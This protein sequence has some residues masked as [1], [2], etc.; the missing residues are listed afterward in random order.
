VNT[1][2]YPRMSGARLVAAYAGDIRF[3]L[4]KM[5]RTPAFAVPTL[6]FPA[7]FYLLFGVLLSRNNAAASLET[8]ARMGVFGTMG[9]GLFGFAVSLAFEREHGLMKFKQALPMPPGA[10]L[11]ARMVM[12]MLF[13]AIIAL[14]LIVLAVTV[15]GTT[16]DAGQA[17]KVFVIEV[18]GVL[19]FCALGLCIGAF[20]SGQASPAIANLIYL[21]MAFLSG[22]WIPLQFLPKAIQVLAPAWPS[23][24]LN[25]LALGALDLPS[26]GRIGAHVAALAGITIVFFVIAMRRLG[27]RGITL[28]NPAKASGRFRLAGAM[29]RAFV[30]LGLGLAAAGAMNGKA[31]DPKPA[32][33]ATAAGGAGAKA[34]PPAGVA[35]PASPLIAAFDTGSAKAAYGTGW[36][37]TS[38]KF[39]GGASTASV[40]VVDGGAAG[41]AGA[42]EIAG[43][44][45]P[46]FQWPFAGAVFFPNGPP[47]EGMMDYSSRKTLVFQARGDGGQFAV[48]FFSTADR[49]SIPSSF[50]FEAGAEWRE[51]RVPLT[52]FVVDTARVRGIMVGSLGPEGDF[53]LQIDDVR[54]E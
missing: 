30:V 34:G 23:Y 50:P 53:R 6:V 38:D 54:I 8:F 43:T 29:S 18:L 41:S 42:L 51:V 48:S 25:Q 52:D 13:A 44:A 17:A 5:L 10:Y 19:P 35:A 14:L 46:G 11:L 7:M 33:A 40:R 22:L 39:V 3:E 20:V 12:S 47:M 9:P 31:P 15:G 4:V 1:T 32:D 2:L 49:N 37:E 45:R 16:L 28:F 21:P 24:H 26:T 27:S 36:S